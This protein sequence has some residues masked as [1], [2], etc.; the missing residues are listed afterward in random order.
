VTLF[1]APQLWLPP[2]VGL[3][4]DYFLYP[5]WLAFVVITGRF[6]KIRFHVAELFF[7]ALIFWITVS[8]A[9]NGTTWNFVPIVLAK[10]TKWLVLYLLVRATVTTVRDL[11]RAAAFLV[12]LIYVL[13]VEGIQ[14]KNSPLG[15]NWAGGTLGWVDPAVIA[16]GGTGRTRW[17][18]V[19]EGMGVFCVA[20][21]M[22]LP[23]VLHYM[24][25]D[26]KPATR[27]L[28]RLALPFLLLAIFYTGSRGG[29]LA[30]LAV[31]SL[32]LAVVYKVSLKSILIAA[33]VVVVAYTAAPP[34]L[35]QTKDTSGSAQDR[36]DV[37]AQ[38]LGMVVGSPLWGVGGGNFQEVTGTLIA[39]NS[40]IQIMGETGM[41]GLFLWL[42][43]ITV[44]LRA[45]FL[46]YQCSTAPPDRRVVAGVMA[47]VFGYV[48]SSMFVTLEYETFYLLLALCAGMTVPGT[49]KRLYRRNEFL[50]CCGVAVV[51]VLAIKALVMVY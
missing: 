26:F 42:S 43:L 28:N 49:Q 47:S 37:W 39:H 25:S 3:S 23:F 13:V 44:C 40:A 17:V 46:R 48:I 8:I 50:L 22:A 24:S 15:L 35:T 18:G 10:Y 51:F 6:A 9:A 16:A 32:H 7:A 20:Y 5:C 34:S 30:T 45:A 12:V 27:W 4:T 38:G 33:A 41:I 36:V 14:H 2:F 19:F 29:F 31:I 21:T 1:I 11:R